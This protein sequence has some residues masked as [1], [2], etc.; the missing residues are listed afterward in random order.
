MDLDEVMMNADDKSSDN[1][2]NEYYRND[3][4]VSSNHSNSRKGSLKV[5]CVDKS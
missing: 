2:N 5:I 1:G 4:R 3:T